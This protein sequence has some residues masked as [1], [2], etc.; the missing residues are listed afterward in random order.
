MMHLF[1]VDDCIYGNQ[2]KSH[3]I[4]LQQLGV[5]VR[6]MMAAVNI[7][8]TSGI[9]KGMN[10]R[11]A[12]RSRVAESLNHWLGVASELQPQ[13]NQPKELQDDTSLCSLD[14]FDSPEVADCKDV[15]AKE[16]RVDRNSFTRSS[17]TLTDWVAPE[18]W[19]QYWSDEDDEEVEV[20]FSPRRDTKQRKSILKM[21]S[22]TSNRFKKSTHSKS[23]Q[24]NS[25]GMLHDKISI[26]VVSSELKNDVWYSNK[27]LEAFAI[28]KFMEDNPDEFES[29]DSNDDD[30]ILTHTSFSICSYIEEEIT[31]D[32]DEQDEDEQRFSL[33]SLVSLSGW[34]WTQDL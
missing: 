14:I 6:L 24:W 7:N 2:Q 30:D 9:T 3:G 32:N 28:E 5:T 1:E 18:E 21:P 19:D 15:L 25:D 12:R 17:S 26:G 27:E 23:V 34:V 13:L 10:T 22:D 4:Q 29:V 31:V 11:I 33:E 20:N 8:E 16:L